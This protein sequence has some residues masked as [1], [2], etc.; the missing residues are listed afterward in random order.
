MSVPK[1]DRMESEADFLY[2][3]RVIEMYLKESVR[4]FDKSDTFTFKVP[5][6]NLAFDI[7]RNIRRGNSIYP[8]NQHEAQLRR[9]FFLT[10]K[11]DLEDFVGEWEI[12]K[13]LIKQLDKEMF[14][15]LSD[16]LKTE[17]KLL[18]GIMKKDRERFRNLP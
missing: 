18:I 16:L 5:L 11:G 6:C 17:I 3:A 1:Y 15:D 9:D 8:L 13:E 4:K 14:F 10:A 12:A 2:F 7:N